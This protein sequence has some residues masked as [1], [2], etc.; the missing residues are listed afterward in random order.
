MSHDRSTY[1]ERLWPRPVV[2]LIPVALVGMLALAYGAALG[3]AVG[4][5][6]AL[7]GC[8]VAG[9][10]VSITTPTVVVTRDVLRVE[11]ACIPRTLLGTP[12]TLTRADI[13]RLRGPGSDATLFTAL[14]PW[15]AHGGV[16]VPV[17]DPADPHPAWIMSSRHPDRL[18]AAL[19]ETMTP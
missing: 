8:V 4:W 15:S 12:V 3:A 10:L 13:R 9:G 1:R 17:D 14:R 2:W 11:R 5:V 16:L 6:V 19:T 18:V 7:A